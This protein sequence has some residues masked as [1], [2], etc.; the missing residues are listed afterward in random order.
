[1]KESQ[2]EKR[3][4]VDYLYAAESYCN[5]LCNLRFLPFYESYKDL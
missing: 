4:A 3:G 5:F 1:M 2:T